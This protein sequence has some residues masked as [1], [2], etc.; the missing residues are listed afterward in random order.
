MALI[1]HSA[2]DIQRIVDVF[3]NASSKFGL[4]INIKKTKVMFQPNSAMTM[5]EDIN[6]DETTLI[7]VKEFTYLG[8]IIA[9]DGHIETE[10]QRECQRPVCHLAAFEK[11]SGITTTCQ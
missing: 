2:E 6:V 9:N 11:D 1:A 7:H 5:V 10:L 8:S 3:A 4:K